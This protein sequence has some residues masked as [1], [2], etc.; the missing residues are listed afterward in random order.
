M[1]TFVVLLRGINLGSRNRI[2][3]PELRD[4]LTRSGFENVRTYVQSGNVVLE[5]AA[6]AEDLARRCEAVIARAFRLEIPVIVRTRAQL[7][8][9]VRRDPLGSV[10]SDPKRYLVSFLSEKPTR[11]VVR[12]LAAAA[13]EPEQLIAS[14]RELYA[15]LP[16]GVARSKLWSLLAAKD[17]GVTTTTRNWTTVT[18]LFELA[19]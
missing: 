16:A 19:S 17:L 11:A 13:V 1:T 15:W 3:M 9:V 18:K 4:A 12:K 10:A 2:S 14:G 5:T 6:A 8:A 7:A